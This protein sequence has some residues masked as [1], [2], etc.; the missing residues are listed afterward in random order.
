MSNAEAEVRKAHKAGPGTD[1]LVNAAR[2]AALEK[3]R[4]VEV[5]RHRDP[6]NVVTKESSPDRDSDEVVLVAR[7]S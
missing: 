6:G 4:G 1:R 7:E 2:L 5:K 3:K